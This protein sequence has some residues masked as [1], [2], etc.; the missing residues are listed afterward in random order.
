MKSVPL[1][2]I[3]KA[4]E[5]GVTHRR[6][7]AAEWK[8]LRKQ[9]WLARGPTWTRGWNNM[10]L[11]WKNWMGAIIVSKGPVEVF[12]AEI[13]CLQPA[14]PLLLIQIWLG[15][16]FYLGGHFCLNRK[17]GWVNPR[18]LCISGVLPPRFSPSGVSKSLGSFCK[19]NNTKEN[20]P[21]V[22]N[23]LGVIIIHSKGSSNKV[24]ESTGRLGPWTSGRE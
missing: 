10:N 1:L 16:A 4:P 11:A 24:P 18:R 22:A 3:M 23:R 7:R 17:S 14:F 19:M 13:Y 21:E 15:K 12:G 20:Q 5:V 9:N 8:E 6:S 2:S